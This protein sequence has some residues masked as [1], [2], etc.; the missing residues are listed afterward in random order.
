[1]G[2][3]TKSLTYDSLGTN[4]QRY[5][6]RIARPSRRKPERKRERNETNVSGIGPPSTQN[7]PRV[8]R[9]VYVKDRGLQQTSTHIQVQLKEC[10]EVSADDR[11][12]VDKDIN[13]TVGSGSRLSYP[14]L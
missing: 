1:M 3:L 11:K 7:R 6:A 2:L 14:S 13:M 5:F 4:F 9:A 8:L 10:V 12:V